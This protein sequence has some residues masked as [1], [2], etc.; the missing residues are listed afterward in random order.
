MTTFA[1]YRRGVLRESFVIF[2]VDDYARTQWTPEHWATHGEQGFRGW[3][4]DVFRVLTTV[5]GPDAEMRMCSTHV[6][7]CLA[8]D[9]ERGRPWCPPHLPDAILTDAQ[10][11]LI[12]DV[13]AWAME[14]S[15]AELRTYVRSEIEDS[16]APA[17]EYFERSYATVHRDILQYR[18]KKG[19]LTSAELTRRLAEVE[20][21]SRE[22]V[23]ELDK[24]L[25]SDRKFR[26]ALN[27]G[28]VV[29]FCLFFVLFFGLH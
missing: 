16:I 15:P 22:E 2:Y 19:H 14:R 1:E 20:K 11:T 25:V 23:A 24:I 18:A 9:M 6:V 12:H 10:K 29:V 26:R 7:P 8:R 5:S 17:K 27:T 21:R 4:A 3:V 13:V 28:I